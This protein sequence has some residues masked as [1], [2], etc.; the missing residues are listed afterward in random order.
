MNTKHRVYIMFGVV[1]SDD[2]VM[3]LFIFPRGLRLNTE[4]YIKSME[5]VVLSWIESGGVSGRP[6]VW[7]QDSAPCYISRKTQC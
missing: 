5:E 4:A 1:T 2:D 6:Y 3:Y 7:Q